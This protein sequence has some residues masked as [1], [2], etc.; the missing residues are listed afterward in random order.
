MIFNSINTLLLGE[1]LEVERQF[2]LFKIKLL[3]EA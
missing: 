2:L 3:K 1:V